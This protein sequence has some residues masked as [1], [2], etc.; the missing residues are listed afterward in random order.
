M[1][2]GVPGP[3]AASADT[4]FAL[5]GRR[6]WALDLAT[7]ELVPHPGRPPGAGPGRPRR[8]SPRDAGLAISGVGPLLDARWA[9]RR[10]SSWTCGTAAGG[11][12][13]R[14]PARSGSS[15]SGTA[16]GWW[17][18][19]PRAPR[20]DGPGRWRRGVLRRRHPGPRHRRVGAAR[21]E[22]GADPGRVPPRGVPAGQWQLRAG[23]PGPRRELVLPPRARPRQ[24]DRPVV[25]ARAS[26]AGPRLGDLGG[27]GRGPAGDLRGLR[28]GG[29][30]RRPPGPVR[31]GVDL[32]APE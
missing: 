32:D 6:V 7:E 10:C 20:R 1:P 5:D 4:V 22:A 23:R 29:G 17:G 18:S 2:V 24:R 3:A 25:G 11:T 26:G 30:L 14:P 15:P 27:L 13:C 12:G 21:P 9:S 19:G 28:R 16:P 8:C 31:R